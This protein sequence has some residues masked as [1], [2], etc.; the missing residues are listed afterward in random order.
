M[1]YVTIKIQKKAP[2]TDSS[3]VPYPVSGAC[4]T[5]NG[6]RASRIIRIRIPLA[7]EKAIPNLK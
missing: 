1:Y 4:N 2:D 3:T 7:A 6:K 5:P